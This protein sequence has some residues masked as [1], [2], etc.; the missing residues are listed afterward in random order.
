MAKSHEWLL[1]V[2]EH[3]VAGGAGS[4]VNEVLARQKLSTRIINLGIPDK[5]FDHGN[6]KDVFAESG[7]DPDSII[8]QIKSLDLA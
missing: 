8:E 3:V 2:E 4:A 7:I 5:I 6:P 1:T